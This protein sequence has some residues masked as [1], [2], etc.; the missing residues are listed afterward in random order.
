[1]IPSQNFYE[2]FYSR[3]PIS[4]VSALYYTRRFASVSDARLQLAARLESGVLA[5]LAY[6]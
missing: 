3:N 4:S 2:K 6:I 5:L 1:M